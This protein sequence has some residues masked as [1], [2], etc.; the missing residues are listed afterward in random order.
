M[1]HANSR[2]LL[3][4][5]QHTQ[6]ILNTFHVYATEHCQ[7][8]VAHQSSVGDGA[9]LINQQISFVFELAYLAN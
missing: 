7:R 2:N 8:L 1:Q 9:N 4:A 3:F 5:R 6:C